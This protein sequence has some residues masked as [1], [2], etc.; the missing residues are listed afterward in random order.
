L[1]SM[2]SIKNG[3]HYNSGPV[4]GPIATSRLTKMTIG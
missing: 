1:T 4:N 3:N 2:V